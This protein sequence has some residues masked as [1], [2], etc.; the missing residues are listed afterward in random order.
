MILPPYGLT[1]INHSQNIPRYGLAYLNHSQ[2][3]PGIQFDY[4]L[5]TPNHTPGILWGGGIC[6]SVT[7]D[8][9]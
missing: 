8:T 4:D 2:T 7:P 9:V 5:R 1:Y 6:L 3:I